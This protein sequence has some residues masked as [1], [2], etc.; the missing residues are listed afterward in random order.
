VER[1]YIVDVL[2]QCGWKVA[3]RGNAA[4]RLGLNRSTLLSRM[5]KLGISRADFDDRRPNRPEAE[6]P[7][8][9]ARPLGLTAGR[10]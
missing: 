5:K 9:R 10:T 7:T 6:T 2:Q 1:Q 4:D 3:G 8:A